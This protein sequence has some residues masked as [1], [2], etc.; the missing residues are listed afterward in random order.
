M[1]D[2]EYKIMR[3]GYDAALSGRSV[4]ENQYARKTVRNIWAKGYALA[5]AEMRSWNEN[6]DY[7][8]IL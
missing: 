7:A 5:K 8:W 2:L 3:E 1:T 6:H 4:N